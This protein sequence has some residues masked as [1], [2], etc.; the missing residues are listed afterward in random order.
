[1]VLILI[2]VIHIIIII[3][4]LILTTT[5]RACITPTTLPLPIL[6]ILTH[7][8]TITH[9]IVR[10]PSDRS[11]HRMANILTVNSEMLHQRAGLET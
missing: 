6:T 8:P 11:A 1:M 4:F 2:M 9:N 5:T 10:L 7:S 3:I